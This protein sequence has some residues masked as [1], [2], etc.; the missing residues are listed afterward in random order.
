MPRYFIILITSLLAVI[1]LNA[2]SERA[3]LP[4]SN[5]V[6]LAGGALLRAFRVNQAFR[7]TLYVFTPCTC[8]LGL[9]GDKSWKSDDCPRR[10]CVSL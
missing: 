4:V 2:C 3:P 5:V 1:T 7:H 10:Q 9:S 6:L 8:W